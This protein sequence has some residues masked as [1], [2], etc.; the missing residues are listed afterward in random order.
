MN[1]INWTKLVR[2]R[3]GR[4]ADYLGVCGITG[5]HRVRTYKDNRGR[6]VDAP[7]GVRNDISYTTWLIADDGRCRGDK[8]DSPNDYAGPAS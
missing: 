8:A 7:V 5:K 6:P 3:D 2:V 4:I 1:K